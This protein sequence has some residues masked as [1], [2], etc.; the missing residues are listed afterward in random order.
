MAVEVSRVVRAVTEILVGVGENPAREGLVETPR[1]IAEM[2]QDIFSGLDADPAKE[3]QTRFEEGHREMVIM[4]DTPFYS[5]CEHHLLPFF[6]VVHI[7]YIP[8]GN[9]VGLSKLARAV[10]VL[11]RR[12]Q[13]QERLTSQLADVLM[14]NL[15]PTGV[16]VVVEAEHLCIAMR[17]VRKPG[18]HIIT[19]ATRGSFRDASVTRQ[20]FLS[21]VQG[22]R[23]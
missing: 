6:G 12:P 13:V 7:G 23:N 21:L 16:A 19:S 15:N 9:I 11:A 8:Q 17:G 1:R 18:T 20:E 5:M 22:R 2:Y 14:D 4:R 10:D 3:L